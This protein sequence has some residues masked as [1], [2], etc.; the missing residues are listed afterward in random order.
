MDPMILWIGLGLVLAVVA[1]L[2]AF[3]VSKKTPLPPP[4]Q[5][6]SLIHI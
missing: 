4:G 3:K 6:L 2:V 1:A 5:T